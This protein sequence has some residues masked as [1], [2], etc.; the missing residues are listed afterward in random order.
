MKAP[1]SRQR[2]R[3]RTRKSASSTTSH[4][5]TPKK[6][7]KSKA[8]PRYKTN[9]ENDAVQ[10][11]DSEK[12]YYEGVDE[13]EDGKKIKVRRSKRLK[14]VREMEE[15]SSSDSEEEFKPKKRKRSLSKSPNKKEPP[16]FSLF[17]LYSSLFFRETKN[18]KRKMRISSYGVFVY[19]CFGF[20][21][22]KR[23]KKR[24][25]LHHRP[26]LMQNQILLVM[27]NI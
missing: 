26:E 23:R 9:T 4:P 8:S 16:K 17:C 15:Q 6:T 13:S 20:I 12:G 7:K 18:G 22:E 11:Y 3:G 27:L 25:Q 1:G 14:D 10:E 24:H 5:S 21:S 19:V 2:Q